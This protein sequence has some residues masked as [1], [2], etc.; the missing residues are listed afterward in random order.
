MDRLKLNENTTSVFLTHPSAIRLAGETGCR[1][2][3][4]LIIRVRPDNKAKKLLAFYVR[5]RVD[6]KS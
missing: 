5:T 6:D 2:R 3:T 1:V 4:R